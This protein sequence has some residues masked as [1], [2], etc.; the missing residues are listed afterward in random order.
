[1]DGTEQSY[2]PS[3]RKEVNE[4]NQHSGFFLT[5]SKEMLLNLSL[6]SK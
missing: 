5:L 3:F 1:M 2:F 4:D 6:L